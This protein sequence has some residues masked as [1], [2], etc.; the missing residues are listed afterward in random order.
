MKNKEEATKRYEEEDYENRVPLF[1]IRRKGA[2]WC[3]VL[4]FFLLVVYALMY[5]CRQNMSSWVSDMS[6]F[7]PLAFVLILA[8]D[9]ARGILKRVW[10]KIL[11][12][13]TRKV[14][15]SHY[16]QQQEAWKNRQEQA[17]IEGKSFDEPPPRKP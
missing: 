8:I 1:S 16:S 6:T 17:E 7:V 14:L 9:F 3:F 5:A 10:R 2:S 12:I 4:F 13:I 15:D 11:N